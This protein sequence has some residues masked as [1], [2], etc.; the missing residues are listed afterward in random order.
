MW[1]FNSVAILL[2][3][4]LSFSS[5]HEI[6][7][8]KAKT[9]VN[10]PYF[11]FCGSESCYDVLE[12]S[13][14]ATVEEVKKAARN[15][16]RRFHPDKNKDA[17]AA[18]RFRVIQKAHEV[19]TDDK[20]EGLREKFEYYLDHPREYYKVSG[21]YTMKDIPK[22]GVEEIEFALPKLDACTTRI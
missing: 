4:L 15:L 6:S 21:H 1:E 3:I 17:D 19:L 5:V 2:V 22:S 16:S 8:A 14:G 18:E 9:T 11:F 12:L 7:A 13:R 20:K 10:D